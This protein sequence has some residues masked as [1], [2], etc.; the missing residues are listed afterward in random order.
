VPVLVGV[1]LLANLQ[2]EGLHTFQGLAQFPGLGLTVQVLIL[3]L[4][5]QRLRR[6]LN[7]PGHAPQ[8]LPDR[9]GVLQDEFA[10]GLHA[11]HSSR[12]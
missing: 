6:V 12:L 10:V 4:G 1:D 3:N 8:A 11:I 7:E 2:A 9:A 5:M